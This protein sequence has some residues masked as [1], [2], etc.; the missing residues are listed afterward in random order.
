MI[1]HAKISSAASDGD[2]THVQG[3]DWNDPHIINDPAAVR[4]ALDL[5][6]I[7]TTGDGGDLQSESVTTTQLGGDITEAGKALLDDVSAAAQRTTLGLAAIAASGSGADLTAD[8]VTTAKLGGDITAAGKALLDDADATA[9]RTTLDIGAA[10]RVVA[11]TADTVFSSAT[12]ADVPI[13]ASG[14]AMSFPVITGRHYHFRFVAVVQSENAAVG[15]GLSVT[16]PAAT[17]FSAVG[18]FSAASSDGTDA[19][20]VGSITASDDAVVPSTVIAINTDFIFV[21]EGILIPSADGLLTLRARSETGAINVTVRR[22]TVGL[23][24]EMN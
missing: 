9:Q 24:W 13:A 23:L 2:S 14:A 17:I 7:A 15:I 5:A 6:T 21:V 10:L 4:T 20:W 18:R 22:G 11:K 3:S 19:E 12:P 1:K 16:I 8:S